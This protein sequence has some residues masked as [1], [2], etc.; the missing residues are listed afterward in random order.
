L[1]VGDTQ[2]FGSRRYSKVY[3]LVVGD[4]QIGSRRYLLNYKIR[5]G[6]GFRV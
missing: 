5:D 1:V 2:K 3:V 4:T 6:I